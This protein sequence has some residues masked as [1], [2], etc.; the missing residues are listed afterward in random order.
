[1]Q[2]QL[3]CV[4]IKRIISYY[5]DLAIQHAFRGQRRLQR[6]QQLREV[7]VQWFFV[8]A[9]DE[10]FLPIAK[11]QRAKAVPLRLENPVFAFGQLRNALSQHWQD[12]RVYRKV[13]A[14]WYTAPA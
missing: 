12:R 4:K 13:H 2:P 1:M 8:A 14:S 11:N 9:L 5:D 10:H 7:T 3:Q 6:L